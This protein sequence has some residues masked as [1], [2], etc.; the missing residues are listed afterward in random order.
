MY[1]F[2]VLPIVWYQ[3]NGKLKIVMF[4]LVQSFKVNGEMIVSLKNAI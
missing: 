3:V 2:T 1:T 4:F